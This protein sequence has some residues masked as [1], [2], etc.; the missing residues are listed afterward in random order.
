MTGFDSSGYET[1]Q[2]FFTSK[3]GTKVPMFVV[4]KKVRAPTAR[5]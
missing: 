4:H 5:L 3:D 2:V 1:K